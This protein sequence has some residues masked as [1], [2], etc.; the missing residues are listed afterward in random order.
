MAEHGYKKS[1]DQIYPFNRTYLPHKLR[2]GYVSNGKPKKK[3]A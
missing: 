3:G 1:R 2:E